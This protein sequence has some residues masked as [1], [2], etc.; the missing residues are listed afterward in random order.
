[1]YKELF[2]WMYTYLKKVKTND[3]PAFTSICFIGLLQG[4]NLMTIGIIVFRR[5]LHDVGIDLELGKYLVIGGASILLFVNFLFLYRKREII[6]KKYENLSSSRKRK[7]L[8]WFWIYSLGSPVL[9]FMAG[10]Y[11]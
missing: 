6:C 11:I 10:I 4:F 1:M 5:F 2:Y 7:G 8:V 3:T 9:V